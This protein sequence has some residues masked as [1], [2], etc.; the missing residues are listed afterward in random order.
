MFIKSYAF[1]A[2]SFLISNAEAAQK[3]AHFSPG[4][5]VLRTGEE[6]NCPAG[7]FSVTDDGELALTGVYLFE[8]KNSK[9]RVADNLDTKG[10][11]FYD[12]EDSMDVVNDSTILVNKETY[13]CGELTK[14][15]LTRK[16]IVKKDVINLEVEQEGEPKFKFSCSWFI[17]K[18]KINS[19]KAPKKSRAT[20][21]K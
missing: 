3:L 16:V 17:D 5:Y 12:G 2:I 10:Q 19:V 20:P 9:A 11:C 6:K 14:H 15:I 18:R 1:F 7:E 4:E 13:K 8:L 21:S